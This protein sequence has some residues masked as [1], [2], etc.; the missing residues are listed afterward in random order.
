MASRHRLWLVL[1]LAARL[2]HSLSQCRQASSANVRPFPREFSAAPP[3]CEALLE[4]QRSRPSQLTLGTRGR[5]AWVQRLRRLCS[6]GWLYGD[7]ETRRSP[8]PN[9]WGGLLWI[10]H[11]QKLETTSV[12]LTLMSVL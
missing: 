9:Y 1:R 7:P 2:E 8:C 5:S 12:R 6:L 3:S 10:G 11:S 4:K